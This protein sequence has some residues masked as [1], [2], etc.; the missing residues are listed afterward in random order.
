MVLVVTSYLRI[1]QIEG[2]EGNGMIG[3][4]CRNTATIALA[5]FFAYIIAGSIG[6]QRVAVP[7]IGSVRKAAV[8]DRRLH[9]F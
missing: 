1:R 2:I 6:F 9:I 7:A 3:E 4:I 8:D 5:K